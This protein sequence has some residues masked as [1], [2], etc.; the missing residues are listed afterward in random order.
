TFGSDHDLRHRPTVSGDCIEATSEDRDR[1]RSAENPHVTPDSPRDQPTR[2]AS[3]HPLK[4]CTAQGCNGE[5]IRSD[6]ARL[7]DTGPVTYAT[8][9]GP[10]WLCTTWGELE[11]IDPTKE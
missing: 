8:G 9:F 3:E 6:D 4:P 5:M 11:W 1:R 10:I 2:P 7:V